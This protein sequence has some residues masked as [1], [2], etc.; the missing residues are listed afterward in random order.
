MGKLIYESSNGRQ[1]ELKDM[2]APYLQNA[3]NKAKESDPNED[4]LETAVL[5][6]CLD[7]ANFEEEEGF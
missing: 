6:I 7:Y 3:F 1:T 4:Q 2:P 5:K